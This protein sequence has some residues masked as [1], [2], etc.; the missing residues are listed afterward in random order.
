QATVTI[1][2]DCKLGE[3]AFRVRTATGVSDLKTFWVGALPVVDEKE[4]NNEFAKPQA[5]PLNCTVHGTVTSE[6]VDYF[7]IDAKKG[8]RISVEIEGVR[9]ATDIGVGNLFDPYIALLDSKRFELATSDD[10]PLFKQDGFL[11]IVAPADDRYVVQVRESSYQGNGGCH[12]RLHVGTFPRPSAIF[13]LGGKPGEEVEVSFLGDPAGVLKKKVKLPAK[14]EA[15]FVLHAEDAGGISPSGMP[16]RLTDLPSVNEVEPNDSVATATKGAVPGAFNGVIEKPGD[17]DFYRFP[18]KKGQVFDIH[19]Y[20]RRMG[21]P[22]DPVMYVYN[23]KG[24]ALTGNDDMPGSPDSYVR[25]SVPAD[26]DYLI[27]VT[28]HLKKGGPTYVYRIEATPVQP[29]VEVAVPQFA[30]YQQDRQWIVVPKGNR[31]ATLLSTS[32]ADWG[33]DLTLEAANLPAGVKMTADPVPSF[34][35]SMPVVFE[36]APDA[37]LAGTLG[38]VRAK[39]ADPKSPPFKSHFSLRSDMVYGSPGVTMYHAYNAPSAP[40]VVTDP[41]PFKISIVE[42]KVPLVHNGSMNLKIVAERANGFK[43]PITIYPL[44]NPPGVGS[45]GAATIADGQ[46]ETIL[47]LNANGGAPVRKWKYVVWGVATVGNGPVWVSSQLATV[48]IAPPMMAFSFDR[49]ATEQGKPTTMFAKVQIATPWEGK[50]KVKL[51]GLPP[52]VT[53]PDIEIAK[54]AKELSFP[55]TVDAAAP[56]G[57]H[58]NLYCQVVVTQNG[59]PIVQNVGSTELRIDKPLVAAAPAAKPQAA[60]AKPAAP[61]EKRLSRL[62]QLRK[63]QEEREKGGK[64]D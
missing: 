14:P 8:Q 9:V 35:S 15:N 52:K 37:P 33:G 60:A 43:G 10:T 18:A 27:S 3:H 38:E 28:D 39:P 42:P 30:Q 26:G 49:G 53:A 45:A 6:D 56:A 23:D 41:A 54:D 64:K 46:T 48:E 17:I 5:I 59:E 62:E 50:A 29:H 16:F 19:C 22:L 47:P 1:A 55:L 63:E 61:T 32:R 36:A 24:G 11:S 7:A 13:P 57:Q 20:A 2:G 25:F 31:Y 12:Y 58:R 44:Y 40:V 4:P 21:S 51:V 34:M